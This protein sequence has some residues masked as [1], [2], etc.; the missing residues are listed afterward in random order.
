MEIENELSETT[1]SRP[2]ISGLKF[3]GLGLLILA[4]LT[5]LGVFWH[6]DKM[7]SKLQQMM[8]EMDRTDTGWRLEDIEAA[9]AEVPDEDNSARVILEAAKQMPKRWPSADFHEE[10]YRL[11]PNELVSGEDFVVLSRELA[12]AREALMIADKL[13]DMPH[14]RHQIHYDRNPIA[15]LLPHLQECRNLVSLLRYEAMRRSW[16]GDSHSAL[17]YCRAALNVGR[18]IGDEPI[19]ISQLVRIACNAMV[20]QAIE[21]TLGQGEPTAE[22]MSQLQKLLE[23]EDKNSSLLAAMRGERAMLHKVFD[24]VESGEI[25]LNMLEGLSRGDL[26]SDR[27]KNTVIALWRMDTREDNALFLSLMNRR[28][29]EVQAPLHEQIALEKVWDQEVR[30]R[31][32]PPSRAVITR[33]L[34][35]AMTKVSEAFRREHA[36][37]RCTIVAL[38]A[39]RYRRDKKAWPESVDQLCPQYLSSVP[40]DPYDGKPLRC[41]REIDGLIIYSIGNDGVDDGGHLDRERISMPGV[42]LGLR[43]WDVNK[44]RQP[45][46]PKP[47]DPNPK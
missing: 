10:H 41:K 44:R 33:L 46:Q 15:T 6:R 20:C 27:L 28:I 45:S 4:M 23:N 11:P 42:D 9:R 30:A 18:S 43:L 34:L 16:K 39:E 1:K 47:A 13:A 22:D 14:G 38:A 29:K 2:W 17:K 37:I 25:P 3:L 19:L 7:A 24:G 32:A 31:L 26:Q 8:A 5:A 40:L 36:Y 35:P 21:Q 12:S